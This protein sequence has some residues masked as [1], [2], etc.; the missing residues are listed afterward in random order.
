MTIAYCVIPATGHQSLLPPF[1]IILPPSGSS[2]IM[3]SRNLASNRGGSILFSGNQGG[4]VL[5]GV[6]K[7]FQ[8]VVAVDNLT[9]TVPRGSMFC[10]LGA[11]GAGKTTTM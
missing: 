10:L 7:A 9:F 3:G 8:S 11:N 6:R 2:A 4:L 1:Y 5:Q